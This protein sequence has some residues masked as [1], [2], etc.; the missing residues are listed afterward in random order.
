MEI[1]IHVHAHTV[2][3]NAYVLQLHIIFANKANIRTKFKFR[4]GLPVCI[5]YKS[6]TLP[7][8]VYTT[9]R[10]AAVSPGSP[11]G[12]IWCWLRS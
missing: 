9:L 5:Q 4:A 7:V 3:Q 12:P 11:C 2:L 10:G 8:M 1:E 6:T